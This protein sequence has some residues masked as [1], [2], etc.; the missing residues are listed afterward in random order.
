MD[1]Q[2]G[3]KLAVVTGSTSEIGEAIVKALA[4][5]G[6]TVVVNGRTRETVDMSGP[7]REGGP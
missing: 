6:A 1:L 2:P 4:A 5:E 7:L 3:G